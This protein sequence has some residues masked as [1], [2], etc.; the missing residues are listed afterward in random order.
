MKDPFGC[1][2]PALLASCGTT[3]RAAARR[4]VASHAADPGDLALLLD[5]LGLRPE[6]DPHTYGASRGR[7]RTDVDASAS[8]PRRPGAVPRD[9]P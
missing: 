4:A 6:D 8:A 7:R 9:V 2:E 5:M 1:D 3:D